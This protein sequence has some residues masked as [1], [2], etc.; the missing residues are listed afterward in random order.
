MENYNRNIKDDRGIYY[1]LNDK[2]HRIDGPAVEWINGDRFWYQ[3]DL[4]HRIDGPAIEY[5][6]GDKGWWQNGKLH[7]IDGPACEHLDGYKRWYYE[8]KLVNCFSQKEFERSLKFKL[9][10]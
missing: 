5:H 6:N 3:N 2:L 8:G 4:L 9:F 10:W 7:R 1:Y